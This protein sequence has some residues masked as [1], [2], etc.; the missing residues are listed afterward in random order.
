MNFSRSDQNEL[1]NLR[2]LSAL[3]YIQFTMHP[4]LIH[5]S[6]LVFPIQMDLVKVLH[7]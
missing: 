2:E 3:T 7:H 5:N 6:K 4:Q 1:R